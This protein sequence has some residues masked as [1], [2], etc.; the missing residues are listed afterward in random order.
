MGLPT[1]YHSTEEVEVGDP[2]GSELPE[3]LAMPESFFFPGPGNGTQALM[4]ARLML[5]S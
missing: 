5:H 4:C 1:G 3:C 2:W